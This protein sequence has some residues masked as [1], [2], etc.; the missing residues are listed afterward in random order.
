MAFQNNPNAPTNG[1]ADG[2]DLSSLIPNVTTASGNNIY[3]VITTRQRLYLIL[4]GYGAPPASMKNVNEGGLYIDTESGVNYT[5]TGTIKSAAWSVVS[6]AAG[7]TAFTAL[8]DTPATLGAAGNIIQV[9]AL[10]TA[11]EFVEPPVV[12]QLF[13]AAEKAK[14]ATIA[15]NADVS[16]QVL[17][18]CLVEVD[19]LTAVDGSVVPRVV[20]TKSGDTPITIVSEDTLIAG[21]QIDLTNNT[22]LS[23]PFNVGLNDTITAVN[24]NFNLLNAPDGTLDIQIFDDLLGKPNNVIKTTSVPVSSLVAGA[25]T[26]SFAVSQ[27]VVQGNQYHVVFGLT[28]NT[29]GDVQINEST[30]GINGL[31]DVAGTYIQTAS[32]FALGVS[33]FLETS[34]TGGVVLGD[35]TNTNVLGFAI[36]NAAINTSATIAVCGEI[37]GFA[38]LTPYTPYFLA[39]AGGITSDAT[40]T[41]ILVGNSNSASTLI[42]RIGS[43]S[44][45]TPAVGIGSANY[46]IG[47]TFIVG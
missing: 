7:V 22:S 27:T 44:S 12:D 39:T 14:L 36:D 21:Q 35:G 9:N 19:F 43:A 6:A 42:I 3:A 4:F 37:G 5:N 29:Q 18:P 24:S 26:F 23:I 8:T 31:V 30:G 2:T 45:T 13:T 40:E 47:S 33:G 10:G 34:G 38:G 20:S 11:L 28:G 41:G 17:N 15:D 16:P 32:F 25:N 46:V 1:T